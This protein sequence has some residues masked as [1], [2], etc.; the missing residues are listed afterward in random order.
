MSCVEVPDMFERESHAP[1]RVL[2]VTLLMLLI[3]GGILIVPGVPGGNPL[4]PPTPPPQGPPQPPGVLPPLPTGPLAPLSISTQ[5][6][7]NAHV[8]EPMLFKLVA[9]P[10]VGIWTAVSSNSGPS[11]IGPWQVAVSPDWSLLFAGL[12]TNAADSVSVLIPIPPIPALHN[13]EFMMQ[14]LVFDPASYEF[15]WTNA[16]MHRITVGSTSGRNV[17]LLRQTVGNAEAQFSVS[18]A[19]LFAQYL[20][21]FG[22]NVTVLDD[23]LPLDLVAYDC[24][25]DC[26]FTSVPQTSEKVAFRVFLQSYG[27]VFLIS[28]PYANS[29]AGQYRRAWIRDFLAM[30]LGISVYIGS[31]NNHSNITAE[32]VSPM[33]PGRFLTMPSFT[34]NMPYT[35][36]NEGGTFGSLAAFNDGDP[37]IVS[38]SG[39]LQVY[40]A[41]FGPQHMLGVHAAGSVAVLLNGHSEAL[42]TSVSNPNAGTVL[43]NLPWALDH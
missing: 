24:I 39:N 11:T 40:G 5:L 9:R 1:R 26:R 6:T 31:G 21:L 2:T 20:S 15:A 16:A 27:G 3:A 25:L 13:A 7:G 32:Q 10:G 17:L 30:H 35:V 37:W 8:G 42:A 36:T 33:A 34:V 4:P 18:Q 14:S 12:T 43:G 23:V 41:V 19:D 28:G 22:H 38:T 29:T